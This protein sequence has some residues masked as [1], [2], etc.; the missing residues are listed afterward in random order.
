MAF[1]CKEMLFWYTNK[2]NNKK[3]LPTVGGGQPPPPVSHFAPSLFP[4]LT[5]PGYTTVTGV[6][7][8]GT[9]AHAPPWLERLNKMERV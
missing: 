5:N 8:G 9:R 4:P 6:A 1:R 2:K 7:K 3:N